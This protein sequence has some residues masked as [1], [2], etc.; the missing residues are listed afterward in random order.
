MEATT[1]APGWLPSKSASVYTSCYCEENVYRLL[2]ACGGHEDDMAA[3]FISNSAQAVAVWGHGRADKPV[4]WDYHVV[5]LVRHGGRAWVCDADSSACV[6]PAT[7]P[8]WLRCSFLSHVGGTPVAS[9]RKPVFRVV[10][11][12]VYLESLTSDR[13]HMRQS[14]AAPPSYA[15]IMRLPGVATNLFSDFVTVDTSRGFGTVVKGTDA[16]QQWA[17]EWCA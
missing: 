8:D 17:A 11:A 7:L 15:P 1:V 9:A 5:A 14:T 16:L 4:I 2:E 3:C 6:W 13:S 10:P 12:P